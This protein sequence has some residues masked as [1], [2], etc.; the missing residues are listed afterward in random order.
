MDKK[1][2]AGEPIP[3]NSR[4][5]IVKEGELKHLVGYVRWRGE[6]PG[7]K[8]EWIGAELDLPKGKHNGA[9]KGVQYFQCKPGHGLF[10]KP[11][12]VK[13]LE[14]F[15]KENP[16]FKDEETEAPKEKAEPPEETKTDVS[17][18]ASNLADVMTL[19]NSIREKDSELSNLR[20]SI[21]TMKKKDTVM[22]SEQNKLLNQVAALKDQLVAKENEN[23]ELRN[24][25]SKLQLLAEMAQTMKEGGGEDSERLSQLIETLSIEKESLEQDK[26]LLTLELEE[27]QQQIKSLEM[28]KEMMILEAEIIESEGADSMDQEKTMDELR[29]KNGI[30]RMA[31]GK[32]NEKYENFELEKLA[33]IE[34]LKRKVDEIPNL[35]N[36]IKNSSEFT[37]TMKKQEATINELQS[38]I[39]D[40]SNVE[41]LLEQLT[42]DL[43]N[44]EEE[45]AMLKKD[46]SDMKK[47]DALNSQIINDQDELVQSM[48]TSLNE[49]EYEVELL[50][51]K[52]REQEEAIERLNAQ[53]RK[54]KEKIA[55]LNKEIELWKEQE[56]STGDSQNKERTNA[57]QM[58]ARVAK[59]Q[60]KVKLTGKESFEKQYLYEKLRIEQNK[61][62]TWLTSLSDGFL[63][64]IKQ[65]CL[66]RYAFVVQLNQVSTVIL[67]TFGSEYIASVPSD[68]GK[69]IHWAMELW[70]VVS[71]AME[72][73]EVAFR[74][75]GSSKNLAAGDYL[76]RSDI[77]QF[78]AAISAF[79]EQ[80]Y[81]SIMDEALTPGIN[82]EAIKMLIKK[83]DE[84]LKEYI[85]GQDSLDPI[86][87]PVSA[88][89]KLRR[90]LAKILY[91][92]KCL[93]RKEM[94]EKDSR[95]AED[96]EKA[97]QFFMVPGLSSEL[98]KASN[99]VPLIQEFIET[100]LKEIS[101]LID[102]VEL[103]DDKRREILQKALE[104]LSVFF[105]T[106]FVKKCLRNSDLLFSSKTA[107]ISNETQVTP[108][109]IN[110]SSIYQG[111]NVAW[112]GPWSE[113][114]NSIREELEKIHSKQREFDELKIQSAEQKAIIARS[115]AEISDL[116]RIQEDL[117]KRVRDLLLK[118]NEMVA[119]KREQAKLMEKEASISKQLA[120]VKEELEKEKGNTSRLEEEMKHKVDAGDNFMAARK[121]NSTMLKFREVAKMG[122]NIKKKTSGMSY[123]DAIVHEEQREN[124]VLNVNAENFYLR[125]QQ[126]K[127]QLLEFARSTPC[128]SRKIEQDTL[129][130]EQN[131]EMAS[132]LE[133]LK[134]I[135]TASKILAAKSK[136]V[137]LK[138]LNEQAQSKSGADNGL[139]REMLIKSLNEQRGM[140]KEQVS[141]MKTELASLIHYYAASRGVA[142]K[143]QENL[144]QLVS[145]SNRN[146][147]I[148]KRIVEGKMIKVGECTM[149]G[150][151]GKSSGKWAMEYSKR[152]V[153]LVK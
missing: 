26:E 137:S 150:V 94:V 77:F 49:R 40:Y 28:E 71:D 44:K 131:A 54:F 48:Q 6:I 63:T 145:L 96:T 58:M 132:K 83:L 79:I 38:R 98:S 114:L 97:I 19:R 100:F 105:G 115:V 27:A 152:F 144:L 81:R 70:E 18:A 112:Q 130:D 90:S 101:P 73:M 1:K 37:E 125:G 76:A 121:Q 135:E 99:E 47:N 143:S 29:K 3:N 86:I 140:V 7:A 39:D 65:Y 50:L 109:T 31:I 104:L 129:S 10:L 147:D 75:L 107:D 148:A 41:D 34:A 57:Q 139:L 80:L 142:E 14:E 91:L 16:S 122:M 36:S 56:Q 69:T 141:A 35:R 64:G 111:P 4:V 24:E 30:L 82:F 128:M 133:K 5:I 13:L 117:Q 134:G 23:K 113:R 11:N 126:M 78:F 67:K 59:L 102:T 53:S 42:T 12:D 72:M 33:E 93:L 61:V 15:K 95:L 87:L 153:D 62:M 2:A 68:E 118:E 120:A 108:A 89:Q 46:L 124:M 25:C 20:K 151:F 119:L 21:S 103:E 85:K 55:N 74:V 116:K 51:S 106:P 17:P 60:E 52:S 127:M 43:I 84:G 92:S 8:G 123:E 22:S 32:L 138:A 45:I 149:S 146:T 136:V 88:H 110:H 66:E 9:S